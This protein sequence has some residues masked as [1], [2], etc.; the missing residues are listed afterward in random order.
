MPARLTS[1]TVGFT[2]TTP[3][4]V[5]G[6]KTGTGENG[7]TNDVAAVWAPDGPPIAVAAYYVRPGRSTEENS[8]VLAEVGK[9]VAAMI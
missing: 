7:E 1:P 6:D 4:W 3:D 2:V 9:V 8:A 5:A